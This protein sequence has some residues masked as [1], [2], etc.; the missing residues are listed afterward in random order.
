MAAKLLQR[1]KEPDLLL[2]SGVWPVKHNLHLIFS[3]HVEWQNFS[4]K[5]NI[6]FT[7]KAIM[8]AIQM[9][10]ISVNFLEHAITNCLTD[11]T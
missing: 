8:Y 9:R 3:F 5:I 6:I 4:D 2:Q 1:Q 7:T 10:T 11:T